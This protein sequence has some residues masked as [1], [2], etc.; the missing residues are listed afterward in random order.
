MLFRSGLQK[1]SGE[2]IAAEAPLRS[3]ADEYFA[4]VAGWWETRT[5]EMAQTMTLRLYP[6]VSSATVKATQRWLD[7]HPSASKGLVRLM[8][9]NLADAERALQVQRASSASKGSL[10]LHS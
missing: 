8:R 1:E 4:R 3:F 9:E 5:L 6:P 7:D 10:N 2:L